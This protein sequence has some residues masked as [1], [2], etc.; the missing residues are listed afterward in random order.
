MEPA[1]RAH[2]VR[3]TK[4]AAVDHAVMARGGPCYSASC[5]R[6][7]VGADDGASDA[8]PFCARAKEHAAVGHAVMA[9]GG[10]CYAASSARAAVGAGDGASDAG[11]FCARYQA[12][13]RRSRCDGQ[14]WATLFCELCKSSS[15][16]W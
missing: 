7:A 11:T 2:S 14:R 5:A 4:H 6:A 9:R 16:S 8:G 10:P 1:M 15:R 13:R 3:A 12:C